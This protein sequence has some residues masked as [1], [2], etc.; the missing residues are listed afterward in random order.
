MPVTQSLRTPDN[1]PV[2]GFDFST[3]CDALTEAGTDLHDY[4][5]CGI[6]LSHHKYVVAA[7][8]QYQGVSSDRVGDFL[9]GSS[10]F[11]RLVRALPAMEEDA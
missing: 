6:V 8:S 3:D 11:H 4:P 2:S 5:L 10:L 9:R 1:H 7:I